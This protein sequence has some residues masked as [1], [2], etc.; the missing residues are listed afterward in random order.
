[1][2]K[3]VVNGGHTLQ[4]EAVVQGSKNALL[5]ILAATLLTD[6]EVVL[7]NCPCIKDADNMLEILSILGAHTER[8]CH[9]IYVNAKN[10]ISHV[11]PDK[12][13]GEM[14]SSIFMMGSILSRFSRASCV[15]PGGCA[16]GNRPIDLHL[17]GL[18]ALGVQV[19]EN[20]GRIYCDAEN[21]H[22]AD[23]HLDFPSVGATEN[24]MMAAAGI[25][26]VTTINNAAREPEITDLQ[27]FMRE[28]GIMV[29]GAG[30]SV[31]TVEG[32][33]IPKNT[34]VEYEIMP[35][36]IVAGTL[37]CAAA[38]TRS[39]ITLKNARPSDMTAVVSKMREMGCIVDANCDTIHVDAKRALKAVQNT[40][41][42]PHPGFPT[43]MQAPLFAVCATLDGTS[44]IKENLYENRFR[45]AGELV[46]MGAQVT[47]HDRTAIITGGKLHGATVCAGDL[48]GG[49]ALVLAALAADGKTEIENVDMCVDR[50]YEEPE[51]ILCE[52]GADALRIHA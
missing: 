9:S 47:L 19:N 49:A 4:G 1:M 38:I 25:R 41:T 35:D 12:Q 15:Y 29:Y 31:I 13:S 34:C 20:D 27:N 14:R 32:T 23:I 7:N 24:L 17:K 30:T 45:H 36:R 22:A 48:R 11:M 50:G 26:G 51:R 16:I 2:D 10:V 5:P 3:I 6:G 8:D 40:E 21:A 28:L 52:L 46:K 42:L 37:M 44:V 33:R 43:D 18:R 39:E